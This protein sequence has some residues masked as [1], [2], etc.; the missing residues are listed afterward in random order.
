VLR[1][2][3]PKRPALTNIDRCVIVWLYRWFPSIVGALAIVGPETVIRWHRL[4]FRAY[5]RWRSR[6]RV[7]RPKVSV[8]LRTLIRE[9][10]QAN[11]LWGAPRIHGELLK[12][13]FEVA[14]STVAKYMVR[15]RGPPSQ[16]WKTFLH[17]HVPHIG[18]IDFVRRANRRLQV[19]LWAGH[20]QA[21]APSPGLDQRHR[22]PHCGLDRPPDHRGLPLG[23]GASVPH[24]RQGRLLWSRRNT[25]PRGHGHPGLTN[26]TTIALAERTRRTSHRFDPARVPGPCRD[27]GRSTP[28]PDP[29]HLRELLQRA[30]N[31]SILGQGHPAPS[32]HRASWHRH[33]AAPSRRPSP[34]VL[35]N[36]IFGTHRS[37]A[38]F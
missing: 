25:T 5:W 30:E 14:Q 35:P 19:A 18:A 6:N 33:I 4:G 37:I 28:A 23:A 24:S 31:S 9:M 11:P 10:N 12:L 8:E 17:N 20:H 3:M 1:R 36:L 2:R 7:G 21:P 15:R 22:Q 27:P 29:E 32:R 13:G 26:G 34:S 16:G 38:P